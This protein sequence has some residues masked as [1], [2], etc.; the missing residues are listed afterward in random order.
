MTFGWHHQG[1]ESKFRRRLS[2]ALI[3]FACFVVEA[4]LVV[5]I[6]FGLGAALHTPTVDAVPVLIPGI[7]GGGR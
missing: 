3:A 7:D 5:G 4:A 6:A 2:L 1:M